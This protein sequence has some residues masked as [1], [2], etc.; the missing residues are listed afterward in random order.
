MRAMRA[1]LG[2][3]QA[4]KPDRPLD[5]TTTSTKASDNA[6]SQPQ[7]HTSPN[8]GEHDIDPTQNLA[9]SSQGWPLRTTKNHC[10][11]ATT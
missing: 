3:A 9:S 7:Q 10:T 11:M 8:G 4:V 6:S 1:M 2:K 5:V